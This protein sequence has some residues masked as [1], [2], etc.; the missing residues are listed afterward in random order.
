M[1]D[2]AGGE[3]QPQQHLV[4]HLDIDYFFAQVLRH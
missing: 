4:V 2:K 3:H 1:A